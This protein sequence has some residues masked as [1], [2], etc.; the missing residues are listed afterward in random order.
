MPDKNDYCVIMAG[1][2]GSRFWPLSKASRP[3]QFLDILGVGK[4]LLRQTYERYAK[5]IFPENILVV[6]SGEYVS[7]VKD[8][9]PELSPQQIL[10]EPERRN[11]APCIAYAAYRVRAMNPDA[12]LVVAP[13]D[14]LITKEREF[15]EV[16]ISGLKFVGSQDALLTIGIKPHY[17]ETGY[18]YIQSLYSPGAK[19]F[20]SN[21]C[22]VKTFTE[23]PNLEVAQAFLE[24][25]DF[26]WNSG[27]FLWSVSSVIMAFELYAPS[28]YDLFQEGLPFYNTSEEKPFMESLYPLCKSISIDYAIMEKAEN[29]YMQVADFGWSDLGTWGSLYS[30]LPLDK[31]GNALLNSRT[32]SY[33]NKNCLIAVPEDKIA[34]IEGLNDYIVAVSDN[35]VL[36]CRRSEE[37]RIKDFLREVKIKL[38]ENNL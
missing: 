3:K 36:I 22:R 15:E 14:H 26:F 37:Q 38:G 1:G 33:D 23:K 17:P 2:I 9:I 25:G 21:F 5:I 18:G 7:L 31:D 24:S 30:H 4:S 32:F 13:S 34:V 8:Q 29:V 10:S 16:I 35:A 12:R 19:E 11:T 27:I 28:I 6:T 20:S